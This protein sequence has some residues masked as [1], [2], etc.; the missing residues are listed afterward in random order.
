MSPSSRP[1]GVATLRRVADGRLSVAITALTVNRLRC[2]REL[3]L[4]G[5]IAAAADALWLTPSAVSQQ[6]TVL[7]KETGVQL[8]ERTG[9]GVT[10]TPAGRALVERAERVFEALDEAEAV[11]TT[12]QVE[13]AGCIRVAMLPSLVRIALPLMAAMRAE[14]PELTFEI[15]D[16]ETSQAL[17][18]LDCG[19]IDLAVADRQEW[20]SAKQRYGTLQVTELFADPIV[21]VHS[22][23]RVPAADDLR[24]EHLTA[25]PWVIGQPPWSFLAPVFDSYE[26]S[27]TIPPVVARVH[28][29]ATALGLVRQGWGVSALPRLA[30]AGQADGIAW[31]LAHPVVFRRMVAV[32]RPRGAGVPAI[33]MLVERLCAASDRLPA[34]SQ[35]IERSA[36]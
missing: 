12:T 33:R 21:V 9:R 29:L 18:A 16:L 19:R 36:P 17:A 32:T 7:H 10:L 4:R 34:R 22:P 20:I 24:W 15:E 2:L 23:D 31:Q 28:D 35:T 3:A 13:P 25:E 8:V 26:E 27:G 14:H 30:V 6:I 11:L 1:S 5:S